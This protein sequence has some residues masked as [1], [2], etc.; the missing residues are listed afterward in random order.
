MLAAHRFT[1]QNEVLGSSH[2]APDQVFEVRRTPVLEGELVQVLESASSDVEQGDQ[3]VSSAGI[4][5]D[6]A[7]GA[8][9]PRAHWTAW[10]AVDDFLESGPDDR[11]YVVDR[12][13]GLIGFGD[14][15]R[16][17]I[18]PAGS[19]NI[20]LRRYESGGGAR[21]NLPKG[22]L[23]QLRTAVPY[24]ESVVNPIAA[25]G[26]ADLESADLV[27]DRGAT[28]L[29]HRQR[30]VT[31]EDYEDLARLASP[32]VSR[33]ECIPL[34]DLAA[35]PASRGQQPGVVSL[36]VVPTSRA[37]R[38]VPDAEALRQ[39]RDYLD[40]RRNPATELVV[41]GPDYV[42]I[43]VSTSSW[44]SPTQTMRPESLPI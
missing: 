32:Q 8:S 31:Y 40:R 15:R 20:R 21:G 10:Q 9:R 29:R 6:P 34:Y 26:G 42:Q 1:L 2:A 4:E 13:R 39:V 41:V 5:I 16:G 19:N 14:G 22:A 37:A 7:A 11:H 38:P 35:E 28:T 36:I 17:R 3:D 12:G 18:P 23:N 43:S 27:R 25:V 30:A 24:I 44:S 33:V